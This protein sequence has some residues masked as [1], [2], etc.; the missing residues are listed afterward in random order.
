[1]PKSSIKAVMINE[2]NHILLDLL[3]FLNAVEDGQLGDKYKLMVKANHLAIRLRRYL[4]DDEK[5]SINKAILGAH[6]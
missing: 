5:K 1:M 3:S 4:D 2:D 6:E